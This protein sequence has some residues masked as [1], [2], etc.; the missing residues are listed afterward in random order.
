MDGR[1]LLPLLRGEVPDDWRTY[2]FSELHFAEPSNPTIWERS[3]RTGPSM[4]AL[5]ILREQRFTLVEFAADLPPILYDHEARG[6]A[7]NVAGHPAYQ[8]ELYRLC[9]LMLRHRM[10]NMDHTLSLVTIAEDGPM[11]TPRHPQN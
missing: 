1:S 7:E 11:W 10:R 9:L 2:S 6:E 5:S 4:S 3:L 8:G